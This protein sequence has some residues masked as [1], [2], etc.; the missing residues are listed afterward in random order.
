MATDP[1]EER[2][3]ADRYI[4]A[5]THQNKQHST[6]F[7][8]GF[9]DV[10]KEYPIKKVPE[11]VF[12]EVFLP[13]MTGEAV[14]TV[15]H[16]PIAHWTGLVGGPTFPAEVVGLDGKTLFVVPPMYDSSKIDTRKEGKGPDRFNRIFTDM[17]QSSRSRPMDAIKTFGKEMAEETSAIIDKLSPGIYTWEPV[18]AFYGIGK[19]K[20]D[21]PTQ[22]S[23]KDGTEKFSD[24]ELEF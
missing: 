3:R 12:R 13:Y 8:E 10:I 6:E 14:A 20:G 16:N 1:K 15:D 24:D 19:T 9:F 23:V 21:N 11:N 4:D 7:I 17:A 2:N 5:I 18:F 22:P